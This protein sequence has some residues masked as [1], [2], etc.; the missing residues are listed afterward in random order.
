MRR[1]FRGAACRLGWLLT[2]S[3]VLLGC[4]IPS[5]GT[6]ETPIKSHPRALIIYEDGFESLTI[7]VMDAR[8]RATLEAGW[9]HGLE[10]YTEYLSTALFSDE[11]SQEAIRKEL[12]RKYRDRKL[13]LIVAVGPSAFRFMI[14]SHDPFFMDVPVVF[15]GVFQRQTENLPSQP[16]FTGTWV[17]LEPAKSLQEALRLFPSTRHVV[18]VG[19]QGPYDRLLEDVVKTTLG[20]FEK[21]FELLYLT[22]L[23]MPALLERLKHL[24]SNTIVLFTSFARDGAGTLFTRNQSVEM[25]ATAANAPVFVMFDTH[26][27]VG[28]VGGYVT[29][30]GVQAEA[31]GKIALRILHGE[32]PQDIPPVT[33][34]NIDMF[35]W[36]QLRHWDVPPSR[37]PAGATILFREP[38]L[39][40][41]ARHLIILVLVGLVAQTCLLLFL[42]WMVRRKGRAQQAAERR[43]ALEEISHLNRVASMG[44]MA[45]SLVHELSQPL[46]AIL[47]NAQAADHFASH[48]R[49][50]MREIHAA[51]ADIA[52]DNKRARAVMNNIRAIFQKHSIVRHAIDLN[53][54]V[55]TVDRL[56]SHDAVLRDVELRFVFCRGPLR[57]LGDEIPL[58]QVVLNLIAN[59]MDAMKEVPIGH[60]IVTVTTIVDESKNC[61]SVTV[62]DNGPGIAEKDGPKL[63][64]PFFTTKSDGLGM[65]LSICQSIVESLGGRINFTNRPQEGALFQVQLLLA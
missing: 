21:Q 20:R 60:R 39:W 50:D 48:Q 29:S 63:F 58:Q 15:C 62:E 28:D 7:R 54:V 52:D 51:L 18:V 57:V 11:T 45:A 24:P 8:L 36:R 40:E 61:G 23:T 33:A 13:D 43:L 19:G 38:T 16:Q 5:H 42:A 44:R 9:P 31:A 6:D 49:P 1:A 47:S 22:D 34:A 59:G 35:D 3:W 2:V 26:V 25:V 41:R 55:S 30:G 14:Q 4:P 32:K 53:E 17:T 65:G 37:I 10:L 64:T 56:V 46:A 12:I 27:G